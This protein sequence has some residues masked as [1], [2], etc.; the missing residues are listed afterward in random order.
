MCGERTLRANYRTAK[1]T[2]HRKLQNGRIQNVESYRTRK[3]QNVKMKK[4][5]FQGKNGK[6]AFFQVV[7]KTIGGQSFK[8][9]FQVD[10]VCSSIGK[11]HPKVIH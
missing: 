10:E 2:K 6:N 9:C 4:K 5:K 11:T 1:I 8:K 3:I 7:G